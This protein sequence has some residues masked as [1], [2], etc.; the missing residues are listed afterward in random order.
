MRGSSAGWAGWRWLGSWMDYEQTIARFKDGKEAWNAW[1]ND[2]LAEKARME[3][4]GIWDPSNAKFDPKALANWKDRAKVDFSGRV[5]NIPDFSQFIFPSETYF[6]RVQFHS[7]VIFNQAEFMGDATFELSVFSELAH[8]KGAKF[9]SAAKFKRTKFKARVNFSSIDEFQTTLN[10]ANFKYSIFCKKTSFQKTNFLGTADFSSAKF[11]VIDEIELDEQGVAF[12]SAKFENSEFTNAEFFY[13]AFFGDIE[14][15]GD[16]VFINTEFKKMVF[17]YGSKFLGNL[18]FVNTICDGDFLFSNTYSQPTEVEGSALFDCAKFEKKAHFSNAVF[19][20]NTDFS[21][22]QSKG[23]FLLRNT[24]FNELP[25]FTQSH[26]HEAPRFDQVDQGIFKKPTHEPTAPALWR[27][28]RRLA[29]QG[30]DHK[31]EN[32]CFANEIISA[33]GTKNSL[34]FIGHLYQWTSDFGRS[35]TRPLYWWGGTFVV[36]LV[37]ILF[38]SPQPFKINS[39]WSISSPWPI[40]M[41]CYAEQPNRNELRK[42]SITSLPAPI[43]ANSGGIFEALS[44]TFRNAFVFL[45]GGSESDRRIYGCLYGLERES[46][47]P[48]V[49]GLVSTISAIQKL[50]SALFIFL[51]GLGVRNML[52]MK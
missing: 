18:S 1:A 16:T 3:A 38:L 7:I 14:F 17:F 32:D 8:F 48:V 24:K 39:A 34:Y 2:L 31:L 26:F 36:A 51:F 42:P 13:K 33:R 27:A 25:D 9:H 15:N 23:E 50:F 20:S 41:P 29:T 28:L 5:C 45:N 52:R 44:L 11:G 47:A 19:K 43:R 46:G 10:N 37:L 22:I 21:G 30:H 12:T 40:T 49:P 6:D 35:I 4:D